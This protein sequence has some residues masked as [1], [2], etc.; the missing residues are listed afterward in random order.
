MGFRTS[1]LSKTA[2]CAS[3]LCV[4][5]V[6][7]IPI[8]PVPI[9][10]SL[11]A[12]LVVSIILGTKKAVTAVLIYILL[13]CIG[14]P[15][16]S[17]FGSGLQTLL[18]PTGGYILSYLPISFI[19][20]TASRKYNQSKNAVPMLI[21]CFFALIVGYIFGTIWYIFITS[22]SLSNALRICVYPF[23]IP[24]IIKCT[25]A[26]FVSKKITTHFSTF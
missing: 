18:G 19:V 3:F 6:I 10:L 25:C 1:E 23:V 2:L 21:S 13:G 15:V 16:F 5:S 26:V 20:A 14:F 7:T 12:V 22:V 24:D 9:S 8:G 4:F 17:G 11:F